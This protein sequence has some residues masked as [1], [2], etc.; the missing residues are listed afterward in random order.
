[1]SF[2]IYARHRGQSDVA[3]HSHP[4]EDAAREALD[5]KLKAH[6]EQGCRVENKKIGHQRLTDVSDDKGLVVSYWISTDD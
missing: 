4:S 5:A 3:R 6:I 1:M 2:C